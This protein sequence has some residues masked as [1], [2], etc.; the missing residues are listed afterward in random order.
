MIYENAFERRSA[1]RSFAV[2]CAAAT[3][4]GAV[5]FGMSRSTVVAGGDAKVVAKPVKVGAVTYQLKPFAEDPKPGTNITFR[6]EVRN[7]S[8]KPEKV[9]SNVCIYVTP[10][11]S[12]MSRAMP[13]PTEKWRTCITLDLAPGESKTLTFETDVKSAPL[14]S[15]DVR[16]DMNQ[17]DAT[18][19]PSARAKGFRTTLLGRLVSPRVIMPVAKLPAVKE[20]A[21]R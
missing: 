11:V 4:A 17:V 2:M 18:A 16:I 19:K 20:V 15:A 8:T 9:K 21:T 13:M 5:T 10:V 7:P 6:V 14:V 1:M 3:V 12:R